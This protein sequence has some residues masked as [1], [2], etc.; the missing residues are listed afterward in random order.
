MIV[1]AIVLVLA[2][3][4]WRLRAMRPALAARLASSLTLA[5]VA[6]GLLILTVAAIPKHPVLPHTIPDPPPAFA[7]ALGGGDTLAVNLYVV[8][9]K[10]PTFVGPA[11]YS[12]EQ[13]IQWWPRSQER[14]LL[15]PMG[16]Y[17]AY[18]DS[19]LDP[20]GELGAGGQEL[21]ADR[22]P[23]QILLL[24]F[25][26]DGFPQSLAD[27]APYSPRLVRTGILRSGSLALHAWLIDLDQYFRGGS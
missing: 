4:A 6:G 10:L 5:L 25:T 16:I 9:A 14:E 27:L 18:F 17:H 23:A 8:T 13:L 15:E 21:I 11:T 19:I 12:G 3:I 20:L 24:S 2:G 26:G 1:V 7:S 22:R